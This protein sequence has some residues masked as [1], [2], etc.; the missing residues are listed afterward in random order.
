MALLITTSI[1]FPQKAFNIR[2]DARVALLFS[3][4]TGSG[5]NRAPAGAGARHRDLPR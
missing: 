4:P 3:D 2:R 1:A 5:L